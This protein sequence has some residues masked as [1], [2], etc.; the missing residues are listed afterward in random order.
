FEYF[1]DPEKT[2][3]VSNEHGWRSLGDMGYADEDGCLYLTDRS[4]FT[5]VSG[6]GEHLPAGGG[7]PSR[8]ASQA[9]R[10]RGIRGSQRGIRRG[11][12]SRRATGGR[13]GG[14]TRT[15]GRTHRVLPGAAGPLQMSTD[16]RLR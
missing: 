15:R 6:W 2:A 9:R 8:H 11:G 13:R 3:S 7:E 16:G 12:Q 10:C 14:R 1:N 5:I 4:T